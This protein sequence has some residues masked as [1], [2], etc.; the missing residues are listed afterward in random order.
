MQSK[1]IQVVGWLV[2]ALVALLAGVVSALEVR[3]ALE[4]EREFL[5]APVCASAPV[6]A[7]A[8]VWDQ[9]FTVR[10]ADT[11]RGEEGKAPEAELVLPS[12]KPW[13][14]T[15]RS[16]DPLVSEMKPGDAV[17]GV[18][19]HG[20][21]VEVRYADGRRQQTEFGP[22]GWPADR[23]G[24]ALACL[25]FGLTA[26][27]G[28]LWA[29]IVRRDR[30]H[31]RAAAMVRWHGVAL[32][33]TALL[34][35]WAQSNNDWP[36][37]AI[38]AIWG[39]LALFLLATM[40]VSAI[41]ALRSD[42]ADDPVLTLPTGPSPVGVSGL[43]VGAED[44]PREYRMSRGRRNGLLA[45]LVAKMALLLLLV[46]TEEIAPSW[47]RLG[48]SVLLPLVLVVF[49]VRVPRSGTLVSGTGIHI[50]GF[51]HTRR[52]AWED[53]RDIRAEPL[54]GAHLNALLPNVIAYAYLT[55]GRRKLLLNLN[56]ADYDMDHEIS[57]LRAAWAE[58]RDTEF[59]PEAPVA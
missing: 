24:G 6:K 35:L 28:S 2:I 48:L 14:V 18:I 21:A 55:G 32:G 17:V 47:M 5:A 54:R 31:A 36:L 41:A 53:I 7:S 19:W 42:V 46:W 39:P 12:G 58:L 49:F 10:R 30:R 1:A 8:C 45:V 22:V 57:F 37:W 59:V 50:R 23:L 16:A 51:T 56:S 27:V 43:V 9:K 15:F 13:T 40:V 38:P 34:T 3:G 33:L 26:L 29:L 20:Q 44:L 11:H 25:S 52:V 4:R